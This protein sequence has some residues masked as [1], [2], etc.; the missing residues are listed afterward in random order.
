MSP[1]ARNLVFGPEVIQLSSSSA[2]LSM[3]F[4]LLVDV[5]KVKISGKLGLSTQ[6]LVTYPAYKC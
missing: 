3:K 6:Q 1:N 5:E 4:H 2:Q